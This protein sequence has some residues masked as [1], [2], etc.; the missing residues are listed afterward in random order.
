MSAEIIG[1][2][3]NKKRIS[4]QQLLQQ[5]YAA[6]E[7]GETD[8]KVLSSGHH[9]IGGPLWTEDGT[10]L[11]FQVKNPGQRVGSFGLEGTRIIVDGP[12]PADAG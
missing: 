3:E 12:A 4:T 5:I 11:T 2:D 8:F 10:P 6:L 1:F 7:R 9:D